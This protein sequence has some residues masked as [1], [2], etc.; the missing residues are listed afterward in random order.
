MHKKAGR[1]GLVV[2]QMS[3]RK[4]VTTSLKAA[5]LLRSLAHRK[6]RGSMTPNTNKWRKAVLN[7][8]NTL[9][10]LFV[11][12]LHSLEKLPTLTV[13]HDHVKTLSV[14]KALEIPRDVWVVEQPEDLDLFHE[15]FLFT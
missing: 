10:T 2:N 14:L 3:Q 6:T 12:L 4:A 13:L 1:I 5:P 15:M 7:A 9:P 11:N 8:L